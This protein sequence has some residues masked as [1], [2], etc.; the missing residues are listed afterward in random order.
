MGSQEIDREFSERGRAVE[1]GEPK[2]PSR[3][4]GQSHSWG[5]AGLSPL[6]LKQN[7][8]LVYNLKINVFL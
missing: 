3:A 1:S 4:Q 7:M 8:K 5:S 2:Y 6:K